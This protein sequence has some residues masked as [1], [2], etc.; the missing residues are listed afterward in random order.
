[1]FKDPKICTQDSTEPQS[2][3]PS[4]AKTNI[5]DYL[6]LRLRSKKQTAVSVNEPRQQSHCWRANA[7]FQH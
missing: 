4:A 3:Q 2:D 7:L 5:A 1:M 6:K